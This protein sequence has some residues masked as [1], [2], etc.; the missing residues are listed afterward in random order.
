MTTPVQPAPPTI[1]LLSIERFRGIKCL[2]W[3]PGPGVNLILGGGDVGKTTILDAISLLL[4]PTNS[5][6]VLDSDYNLRNEEAEFCIE[7]VIALPSG[8]GI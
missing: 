1:L 7:A 4:S 8:G 5:A 6:S 3:R 2:T